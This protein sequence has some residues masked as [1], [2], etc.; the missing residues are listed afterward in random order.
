MVSTNQLPYLVEADRV[1][2]IVHHVPESTKIYA[3][4]VQENVPIV[5][6]SVTIAMPASAGGSS[7]S[8]EL[9]VDAP[10]PLP[11]PPRR[12]SL[13]DEPMRRPHGLP[14]S[15]EPLVLREADVPHFGAGKM[16]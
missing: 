2:N 3:D 16:T 4:R 11:G 5:S 8:R 6:E 13:E 15:G 14:R 7:S 10:V 1:Q 9:P 12:E